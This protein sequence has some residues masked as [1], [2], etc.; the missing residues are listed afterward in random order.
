MRDLMSRI[1]KGQVALILI[2][3]AIMLSAFIL[4]KPKVLIENVIKIR[5][6]KSAEIIELTYN[7]AIDNNIYA[8]IS[9]DKDN[10]GYLKELLQKF[11]TID[12]E[13]DDSLPYIKKK[14]EWWDLNSDD[15]IDISRKYIT[16]KFIP[17]ME[18]WAIITKDDTGQ[19]YLYLIY[20]MSL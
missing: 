18:K 14:C 15:I 12:F 20:Q 8:K 9:F 19:H 10:L 13:V 2:L 16:G 11:D 1:N 4:L 17:P 7:Y 5:L 6:P 3:V